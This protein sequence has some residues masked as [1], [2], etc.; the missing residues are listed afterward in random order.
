M[1]SISALVQDLKTR[2][3]P[4]VVCTGA[5]VSLASGI[6]TFRGPDVGAVWS[7]D[8]TEMGTNRFYQQ[9]PVESWRWYLS[10]FD[11]L[12]DKQPNPAHTALVDL[13]MWKRQEKKLN[14]F[15]LI[16]QNIDGLHRK[17]GSANLIEVH[18]NADLVRCSQVGCANGAPAGTLPRAAFESVFQR[19]R[20]DP[21]IE[22]LPRCPICES[23]L[24]PH[25]LWFDEYYNDHNDYHYSA[26]LALAAQFSLLLFAGTSFSVG[27]TAG[28]LR[29][30]AERRVPVW[31]IDPSA[32][33]PD[34][35]VQVLAM[36]AEEAF[37]RVVELCR[38]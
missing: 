13:E 19:F 34:P 20:G 16:T 6:P 37:P 35:S 18:G 12:S 27:V 9:N 28:L 10:R 5:G 26:V 22:N 4:M 21:R 29:A 25:V 7:V 31:S 15:F 14:N 2:K 33:R 8:V 17:A 30:A 24:R 38:A 23:L 3:G 11:K 32:E 1:S 36:K